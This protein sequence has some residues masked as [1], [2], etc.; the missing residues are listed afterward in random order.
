MSVIN[1]LKNLSSR[2]RCMIQRAAGKLRKHLPLTHTIILNRKPGIETVRELTDFELVVFVN[3][4]SEAERKRIIS[5]SLYNKGSG[6]VSDS[7]RIYDP[8]LA[9][10]RSEREVTPDEAEALTYEYTEVY[11]DSR[12]AYLEFVEKHLKLFVKAD[13]MNVITVNASE[14]EK[15]NPL[16]YSL[17]VINLYKRG[18]VVYNRDIQPTVT[19]QKRV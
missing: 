7:Y 9:Y 12:Q 10:I 14:M 15:G 19:V 6:V 17:Y 13:H 18:Y 11:D 3:A 5:E 4:G 2:Q 1:D 8:G 16:Y